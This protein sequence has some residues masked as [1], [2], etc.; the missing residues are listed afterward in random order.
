MN[1]NYILRLRIALY[2]SNS[3]TVK[4]NGEGDSNVTSFEDL[5][6]SQIQ[7]DNLYSIFEITSRQHPTSS[8]SRYMKF[9]HQGISKEIEVTNDT[10]KISFSSSDPLYVSNYIVTIED[11]SMDSYATRN[12]EKK[13]DNL[14]NPPK[15][16]R[17]YLYLKLI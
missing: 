7:S 11:S 14:T 9:I 12:G 6:C 3:I 5:D 8:T 17:V 13:Y 4:F 10:I 16:H 2:S 15:T 1:D